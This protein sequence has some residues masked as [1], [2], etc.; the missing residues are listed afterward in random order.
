MAFD[1]SEPAYQR[2]VARRTEILRELE[3]IDIFLALYQRF[4]SEE[5]AADSAI[6]DKPP[7]P[8]DTKAR[9]A[10]DFRESDESQRQSAVSRGPL[11]R[12]K[13]PRGMSQ[14]DIEHLVRAILIA[15][16]HPMSA[17]DLVESIRQNGRFVGGRD[18][19]ANL[20]T[21]LW[22]ARDRIALISGAGYWPS[23]IDCPQ[24]GYSAPAIAL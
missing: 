20:K 11:S 3:S 16:G 10:V 14:H 15:K 13:L 12:S 23:D 24:I 19:V 17:T 9:P 1:Q 7:E 18:E 4:A 22:R 5:A 6:Y 2:A 21:K 8:A